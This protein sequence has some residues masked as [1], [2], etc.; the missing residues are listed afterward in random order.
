MTTAAEPLSSSPPSRPGR[1]GDISLGVG[2]ALAAATTALAVFVA[3]SAPRTP[4]SGGATA[5]LWLLGLNLLVI[6]PVAAAIGWRVLKLREANDAG[7]RLHLRFVILFAS[8]ALIPAIVM[9]V[10]FGLLVTQGVDRWLGGRVRTAVESSATVSRSYFESQYGA[11]RGE[12][13][14]MIRDLEDAGDAWRTEPA[15][16]ATLLDATVDQRL[17]DAVY[18]LN[19]DGAILS[20]SERPGA[21]R[22]TPPQAADLAAADAGEGVIRTFETENVFRGVVK[23]SETGDTFAYVVRRVNGLDALL[24]ASEAV[25]AYREAAANRQEVQAVFALIYAETALLVLIA[26]VWLGMAAARGLS[27]PIGRVVQ[28]AERVSAGDLGARVAIG[29]DPE[30]VVVLAQAFNRM[31]SDLR[32]QQEALRAAGEEART[33]SRFIET[34]LSDVSAGVIGVDA[35]G[36]VTTVNRQ[37]L[38]LLGVDETQALGAALP[39]IAPELKDVADRARRSRD[40]AEGEMEI[41]RP[42]GARRIRARASAREDGGLVLTFDDI[43]RLVAAQRNEAWK[44]V[45]R[46]IAHEIKNPLT[47]IQLSAERL[48]RKYR[49]QITSEVEIFDRCTDTIVRQVGDIGRMVDEFSSFARMPAPKF[50]AADAAEMLRQAVFSQRVADAEVDVV[51]EAPDGPVPVIC[52]ERMVGQA[53]INV[54]KNAGEAVEARR[55][56]EPGAGGVVRARLRAGDTYVAFEIEDDGVG[57][58]DSGRE[59]LTEPYVTTREKGTGLGLAIVK[60]ILEDHGG[61]FTLG[62]ALQGGGARAI[63]R[64]PRRARAPARIEA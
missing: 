20:R 44:D 1:I 5:L 36:A 43:T 53:L 2:Y 4:T 11:L 21:P 63:L 46:R 45:A 62:D 59:R 31:T 18:L 50:E 56:R 41:V 24:Q 58:P 22:Y 37:A 47:P 27:E 17:L 15:R 34:V 39:T 14:P 48:R 29:K 16:Y 38:V 6:L 12:L 10:F 19:R 57:L 26:G 32:S 13:G 64:M 35:A 49:S 54:L 61:E 23:V 52:D 51:L 9:A 25:Q 42:G 60:R 55:A 8:A 28:A 40:E 33:R 30:A 3:V 7:S